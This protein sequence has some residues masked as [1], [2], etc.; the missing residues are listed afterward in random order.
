LANN[1]DYANLLAV[2]TPG[3]RN[4]TDSSIDQAVDYLNRADHAVEIKSRRSKT[5]PAFDSKVV[6]RRLP[7]SSDKILILGGSDIVPM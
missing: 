1:S 2:N 4:S 5:K 3:I 6:R 7:S